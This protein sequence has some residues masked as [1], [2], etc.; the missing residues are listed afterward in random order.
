MKK[1]V[2]DLCEETLPNVLQK[3]TP[4][5]TLNRHLPNNLLE[6]NAVDLLHLVESEFVCDGLITQDFE[7]HHAK[8]VGKEFDF[9]ARRR[10]IV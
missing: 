7:E 3:L 2:F 5:F 1:S 6:P 9:L 8:P 4:M 10:V